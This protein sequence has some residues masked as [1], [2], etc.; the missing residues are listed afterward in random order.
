LTDYIWLFSFLK[1]PCNVVP[2]GKKL[3][4]N[5]TLTRDCIPRY[6]GDLP[7]ARGGMPAGEWGE[8]AAVPRMGSIRTRKYQR[9]STIQPVRRNWMNLWPGGLILVLGL[10]L[11]ACALLVAITVVLL[12]M[13]II[14][15][16][17]L[18]IAAGA[19]YLLAMPS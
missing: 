6:A 11:V 13:V 17:L 3:R 18:M 8:A 16:G 14:G 1:Y 5:E 9:R 2:A 19:I 15:A 7:D 10:A 12:K 4:I